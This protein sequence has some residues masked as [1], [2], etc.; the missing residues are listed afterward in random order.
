VDASNCTSRAYRREDPVEVPDLEDESFD[1]DYGPIR[2]WM[3]IPLG[4]RG[5]L[6]IA[7]L[8]VDGIDAFDRRLLKILASNATVVLERIEREQQLV[9]AKEQAE[10]ANELKSA[11][12][13][14]MSHEIRTPLTSIIG[15]AEALG[16]DASLHPSSAENG[17]DVSQFASLIEKSGRRL[18]DTLNS[19]LDFSQLEAGSIQLSRTYTDVAAEIAET[20]DLYQPRA[21]EAEIDVQVDVP[22]ALPEAYAD[23]EAFRRVLRNLLSNAVKFTDAG[24]TVVVRARAA[25]DWVEVEVEDTGIGIDPEFV[26]HLF[27]AFEQ[28]STGSKRTY[29]GSGLGLA[30]AKRLVHLMQGSIDVETEKGEGTCFT[31]QL[32]QEAPA[33]AHV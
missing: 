13:A 10:E 12:L 17:Q 28:E 6:S 32:P 19:V 23:R 14:N 22:D 16:D 24:G 27:D 18:L 2:T 30:V 8:Q 21:R 29:E 3:S 5:V 20:V 15:F 1:M 26:P 31:V 11:F 9:K 33:T 25:G 7:S 4:R